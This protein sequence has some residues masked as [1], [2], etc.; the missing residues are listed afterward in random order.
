MT[1]TQQADIPKQRTVAD[2]NDMA[3]QAITRFQR[4][5]NQ[6]GLALFTELSA[7][8]AVAYANP[9][10]ITKVLEGLLSNAIKFSP[11]GGQITVRVERTPD[12]QAHLSVQDKGPGIDPKRL[13]N[14]FDR[15]YQSDNASIHRFGGLGISLALSKE[16][17]NAHGGKIWVESKSGEGTIF[18]I[19]L[20]SPS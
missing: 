11:Q 20:S 16:I 15:S 14:I 2:L 7:K 8:P 9:V 5:A 13:P 6:G 18:H 10:Q 17:V 19:L 1:S 12:G 3:R 4:L